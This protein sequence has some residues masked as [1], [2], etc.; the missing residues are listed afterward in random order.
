M[1]LLLKLALSAAALLPLGCGES[2]QLDAASQELLGQ[3]LTQVQV[4]PL[5]VAHTGNR[6]VEFHWHGDLSGDPAGGSAPQSFVYRERVEIDGQGRFDLRTTQLMS[7]A[8]INWPQFQL[9][10]DIRAGFY[11]RYRDVQFRDIALVIENFTV[12]AFGNL[13]AVAGRPAVGLQ[14]VRK[15]GEPIRHDL[16][17]DAQTGLVLSARTSGGDG[18]LLAWMEYESIEMG[19]P[20]TM[21]PHTFSNDEVVLPPGRELDAVLGFSADL[22]GILPDGYHLLATAKIEDPAGHIWLKA[23]YTDGIDVAF[24]VTRPKSQSLAVATAASGA[25]GT[26]GVSNPGTSAGPEPHLTTI[27][28]AGIQL[29][30]GETEGRHVITLG[31][32][33]LEDL[34]WMVESVF[35]G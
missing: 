18:A 3:I 24:Y 30:Q 31:R 28:I 20:A 4:A 5:A 15:I 14:L 22:P 19:A 10:Q 23:T 12:A 25:W 26:F 16:A 35:D 8:P 7:N 9:Q 2:V 1:K 34:Q 32:L 17:I 13:L 11:Q 33:P 21:T 27:R 6:R 29:L